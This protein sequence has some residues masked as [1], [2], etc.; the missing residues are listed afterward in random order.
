MALARGVLITAI[1]TLSEIISKRSL[2]RS[3]IFAIGHLRENANIR[4]IIYTQAFLLVL[5]ARRDHTV[6]ATGESDASGSLGHRSWQYGDSL[7]SKTNRPQLYR[8]L[9]S[10]LKFTMG[11]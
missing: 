7:S 10:F 4:R 9:L 8:K 3:Y 2:L 11:F 1:E 5:R 6:S